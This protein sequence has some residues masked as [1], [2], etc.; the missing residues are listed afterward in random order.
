MAAAWSGSCSTPTWP[1]RFQG[2]AAVGKAL[3]PEKATHY[4]AVAASSGRCRH[5]PRS[6]Y[7]HGTADRGYRPPFTQQEIKL[8]ETLPFFTL[9]EMLT[10][11]VVP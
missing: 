5:R 1:P 6:F 10:R 2:F 7:I 4:R 8:D 9:H 11:N 3:D